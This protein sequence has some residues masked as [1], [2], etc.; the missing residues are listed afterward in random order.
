MNKDRLMKHSTSPARPLGRRGFLDSVAAGS[1]PLSPPQPDAAPP[2]MTGAEYIARLGGPVNPPVLLPT[3]YESEDANARWTGIA[4]GPLAQAIDDGSLVVCSH[5]LF[6]SYASVPCQICAAWKTIAP[7]D[8]AE[9]IEEYH[10]DGDMTPD[11]I[12]KDLGY[13]RM[14]RAVDL[15]DG[16][17]EAYLCARMLC[18]IQVMREERA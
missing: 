7:E 12:E 16:P 15:Y 5:C 18:A 3:A 1:D 8:V 14:G 17:S 4:T 2:F 6:V 9:L 13:W 10:E 11:D